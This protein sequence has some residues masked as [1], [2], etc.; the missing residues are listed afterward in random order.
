MIYVADSGNHRIQ[1]FDQFGNF[2][3]QFGGFGVTPGRFNQP[4][5]IAIGRAGQVFVADT[6]NNRI[7]KFVCPVP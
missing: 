5:G 3:G 6:E 7:Q 1:V 2:L 4:R